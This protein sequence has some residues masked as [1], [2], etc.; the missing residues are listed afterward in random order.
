STSI[1]CFYGSY[2][3]VAPLLFIWKKYAWATMIAII[4]LVA[5]IVWRYFV[6]F[7]IFK[8]L[9]G[10]DNYFG[11]TVTSKYYVTNALG[12]YFPLFFV[13]GLMCF[14]VESWYNAKQRQEELQNGKATAE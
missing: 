12:Y 11:E 14:F 6:E 5:T 9:L 4:V 13:Y 8:P 7:G 1:I 2:V 10:F 3:L